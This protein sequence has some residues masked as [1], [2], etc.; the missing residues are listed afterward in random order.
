MNISENKMPVWHSTW[1]DTCWEQALM[2]WCLI[3]DHSGLSNTSKT[4]S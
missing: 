1:Y 2:H 3:M 4:P